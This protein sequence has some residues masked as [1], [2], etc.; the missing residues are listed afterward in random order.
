MKK[1]IINILIVT[2]LVVSMIPLAE[3]KADAE[4]VNAPGA[5]AAAGQAND[6]ISGKAE[7]KRTEVK[8]PEPV[9][10]VVARAKNRGKTKVRWSKVKNADGYYVYT[11]LRKKG[12]YKL[13]K[14]I[15][16]KGKRSCIHK[17]RK[18]RK[19]R[20]YYYK[21][22]AF[23]KVGRKKM[24]S[25][26]ADK[27][28]A[29]NTLRYRRV[30]KMKATAYSGGGLCANGKR[31]KVGRVAVDP[32]VIPLGTWLYVKGY[33]FCQACDTGGAIKGNRIDVYFNSEGRCNRY[34]VRSTKVYVLRK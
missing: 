28:P 19:N 25:K 2:L 7:K 6:Q 34:G 16:K 21:V 30:I 11:A 31:C 10:R 4:D 3:S 18:L 29:K 24:M 9:K 1:K 27:D 5:Q 33:G 23:K 20:N 13:I 8:A 14:K 26:S 32:R 12:H 17:Y 15:G 22:V